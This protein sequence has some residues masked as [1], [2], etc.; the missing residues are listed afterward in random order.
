MASAFA[1]YT[2]VQIWNA[3][4]DPAKPVVVSPAHAAAA[5]DEEQS[6]TN[7]LSAFTPQGNLF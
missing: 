1:E 6:K 4:L 3:V 5:E 7:T 2:S